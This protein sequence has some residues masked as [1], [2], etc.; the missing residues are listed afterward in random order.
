M[1]CKFEFLLLLKGALRGILKKHY[2]QSDSAKDL[3]YIK[4]FKNGNNV[5]FSKNDSTAPK[6]WIR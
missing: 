2:F 5:F 3:K 1:I 6:T 4:S